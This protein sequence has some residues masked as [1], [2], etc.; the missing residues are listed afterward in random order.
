MAGAAARSSTSRQRPCCSRPGST[1]TPRRSHD[2]TRPPVRGDVGYDDPDAAD[3]DYDDEYDDDDDFDDG[4]YE[5]LR[6]GG[7]SR[8]GEVIVVLRSLLALC[9]PASPAACASYVRCQ[10]DP[11]GEPGA[12]VRLTVPTGSTN[13]AD[14]PAARGRRR[15][16][17]R[18]GVPVLPAVQ[19]R[20]G[21]PGRR[22]RVPGELGGLGRPRRARRASPCRPSSSPVH[23]ARGPHHQPDPGGDR[24]RRRRVRRRPASPRSCSWRQVRPRRPCRRRS[25][26]SRA[27]CSRTRTRSRRGRTSSPPST[28]WRSSSTP[29]PPRST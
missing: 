16:R 9:P 27:S 18:P 14:R 10:L 23:R 20:G 29:S 5:E 8:P 19:G 25:R 15:H 12:A 3:D 13:G 4:E 28:A 1:P 7:G 11:S 17:R 6:T 2:M 26:A 22:L 21:L 24:R